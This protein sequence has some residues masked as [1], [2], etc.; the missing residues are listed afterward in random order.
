VQ[1]C[2]NTFTAADTTG[3]Y[4]FSGNGNGILVV[5]FVT[6][7]QTFTLTVTVNHNI[8][9]FDL[10]EF[11]SGTMA[12]TYS[13]GQKSQ[14]DF[15]GNVVGSPN[16]VPVRGTDYLGLIDLTLYYNTDATTITYEPAFAHAPGD[17]TTFTEDILIGY[18]ASTATSCSLGL[19]ACDPTMDGS[20]PGLSSAAAAAKPLVENDTYCLVSPTATSFSLSQT[21]VIEITFQLFSSGTCPGTGT[22]IRDK[23]AHFTLAL[24]DSSGNISS[25][26]PVVDKEEGNKVHWDNKAGVNEFDLSTKGLAPG[27]YQVTVR[28]SKTPP[29]K[30]S[31]TLTP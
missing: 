4:D 15:T 11:P 21:K 2:T 5:K 8:D 18:S 7:L 28:S 10:S 22:P 3:N 27:N 24:F 16:G 25:F 6:V 20:T 29:Q 26:P 30:L 9:Q 31:F 17:T 19:P 1:S 12:I 13:N 23:T 14:Y